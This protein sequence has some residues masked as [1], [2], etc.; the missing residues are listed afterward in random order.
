MRS[1]PSATPTPKFRVA[2]RNQLRPAATA[3]AEASRLVMAA[4]RSAD[5]VSTSTRIARSAPARC[6]R[7]VSSSAS[8]LLV[9]VMTV[10]KERFCL[11]PSTAPMVSALK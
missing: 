11:M 10:Q 4:F 8:F 5:A 2:L 7:S 9:R 1:R 3:L 6:F